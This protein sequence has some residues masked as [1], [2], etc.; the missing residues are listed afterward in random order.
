MRQNLSQLRGKLC[1]RKYSYPPETFSSNAN[2]TVEICS[3]W[4]KMGKRSLERRHES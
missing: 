2:K 1:Q 3:L 4:K